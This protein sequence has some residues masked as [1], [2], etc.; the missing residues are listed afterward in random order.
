MVHLKD[1]GLKPAA[2]F[3]LPTLALLAVIIFW[4]CEMR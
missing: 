4:L 3:V 2:T 1:G